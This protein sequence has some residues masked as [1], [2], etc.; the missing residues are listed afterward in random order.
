MVLL[1]PARTA[2]AALR[3]LNQ[4]LYRHLLLAR[5]SSESSGSLSKLEAKKAMVTNE[6]R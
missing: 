6:R 1:L 2:P 4:N 5:K 3:M